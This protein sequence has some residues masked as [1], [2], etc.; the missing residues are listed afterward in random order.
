MKLKY[1]L[2]GL[3][4]GIIVTALIMGIALK[5][6]LPLTDAEIRAK[7]LTLGMV[8]SDSQSLGDIRQSAS[9]ESDRRESP[10]FGGDSEG[11]KEPGKSEAPQETEENPKESENS[12]ETEENPKESEKSQEAEENPKESEKSQETGNLKE[13]EGPVEPQGAEDSEELDEQRETKDRQDSGEPQTSEEAVTIEVRRGDSSGAVARRLE[14]AGLVED[15]ARFDRYLI[16]N[17]LSRRV[18]VGRYEIALGTAEEEIA[19]IITKT[20]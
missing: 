13:S 7:A 4:I 2:R 18:S 10:G 15:A 6:R 20:K 19:K 9:P 11:V 5:D 16:D 8:D 12:Q 3:G 1:Y 17:E 14:E